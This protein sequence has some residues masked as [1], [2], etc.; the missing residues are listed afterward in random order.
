MQAKVKLGIKAMGR[1]I[2]KN[3]ESYT[4]KEPQFPYDTLF[5]PEMAALSLKNTYLWDVCADIT[6]G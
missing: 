2:I 3:D 4:L 1:K 5:T 6:T